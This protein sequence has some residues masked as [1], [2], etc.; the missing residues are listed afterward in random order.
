MKISKIS[1]VNWRNFSEIEA[2]LRPR[3]FIIGPNASGKSNFLDAFRFLRDI[4]KGTGGGLQKAIKDRGGLSM[5]R[6][7][8]ARRNPCVEFD[9]SFTNN[10]NTTIVYRYSLA[11]KQETKGHRRPIVKHEKVWKNGNLLFERPDTKDN[12]DPERLTETHLEQTSSNKDFRE[13]ARFLNSIC[14]LHLV[15]QLLRHPESFNG[16]NISDDPFG[17]TFLDRLADFPEKTRLRRLHKIEQA[18]KIIAPSLSEL[19]F[20]KDNKGTPH[21]TALSRHWR[22]D[23]GKQNEL[24]FSDGT[25]RAIGLFW[26][27]MENNSILLLEEPELSLNAEIVKELPAIIGRMI[28]ASN[29]QVIISTHSPDL[30]SDKGIGAE[31]TIVLRPGK[32]GTTGQLLNTDASSR[33]L[34]KNGM[35]VGEVALPFV[36]PSDA[37]QMTLQ[38][39]K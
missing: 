29:A 28:R 24:Q 17:K 2:D 13:I 23:A 27:L 3:M 21:L 31:E 4:A 20:E 30:L 9:L 11:I 5:I 35:S 26:S 12:T 33:E 36:S 38:F 14:Y 25:L 37:Y 22:P 32:E 18:L 19:G 1:L 10:D 34:L 16:P 39:E 7:F 8:A 6:C 15:P